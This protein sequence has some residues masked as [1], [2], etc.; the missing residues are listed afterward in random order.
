MPWL[1]NRL[2][3]GG[4]FSIVFENIL[5]VARYRKD[6]PNYKLFYVSVPLAQRAVKIIF[7]LGAKFAPLRLN[8]PKNQVI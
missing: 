3:K 5:P 6:T 2:S 8:L 1:V 4:D 7:P